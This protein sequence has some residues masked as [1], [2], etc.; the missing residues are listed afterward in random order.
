MAWPHSGFHAHDGVW[1]AAEDRD[2]AVRVAQ[3]CARNPVALGRLEAG[4][5]TSC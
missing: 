5:V 3:H 4:T 2:F 1:V